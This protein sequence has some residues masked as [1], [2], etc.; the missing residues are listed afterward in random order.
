MPTMTEQEWLEDKIDPDDDEME[1][2]DPIVI[3]LLGFD[4]LDMED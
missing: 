3:S 4:P 1:T 2:T